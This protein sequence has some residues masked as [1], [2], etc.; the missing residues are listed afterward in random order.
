MK[1][2]ISNISVISTIVNGLKIMFKKKSYIHVYKMK[3]AV[4]LDGGDDYTLHPHDLDTS[5]MPTS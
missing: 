2:P 5:Q 3:R 1:D 4:E